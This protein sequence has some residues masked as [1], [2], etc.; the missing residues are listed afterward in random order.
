MASCWVTTGSGDRRMSRVRHLDWKKEK[1]R[2]ASFIT[3]ESLIWGRFIAVA[4]RRSITHLIVRGGLRHTQLISV[5]SSINLSLALSMPQLS[6]Q[7][8]DNIEHFINNTLRFHPCL[9]TWCFN[10]PMSYFSSTMSIYFAKTLHVSSQFQPDLRFFLFVV[11]TGLS[12]WFN[13]CVSNKVA[14]VVLL[15][16]IHL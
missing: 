14:F 8:N 5:K 16:W 9:I 10:F 7:I 4:R 15:F 1:E 12:D 3:N 6:F 13:H 2:A 11:F